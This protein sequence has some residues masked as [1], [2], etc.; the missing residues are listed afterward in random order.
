MDR[1]KT[2]VF[3]RK[4]KEENG[5]NLIFFRKKGTS[6]YIQRVQFILKGS[7]SV[8]KKFC[9]SELCFFLNIVNSLFKFSICLQDILKFI[10]EKMSRII[11]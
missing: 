9:R 7:D 10:K 11:Q 1:K 3:L 8:K 6:F 4:L 2:L 5:G